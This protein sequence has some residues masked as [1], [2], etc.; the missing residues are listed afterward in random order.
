MTNAE[1]IAEVN[2]LARRFYAHLGYE[3]S[4]DFRFYGPSHNRHPQETM[5]W[6]MAVEAVE[7]LK[8]TEVSDALD[9]YLEE[10]GID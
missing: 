10:L 5:C 4:E 3:V 7:L 1:I 8:G 6:N 9:E 2:E